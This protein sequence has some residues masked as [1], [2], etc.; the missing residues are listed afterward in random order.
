MRKK[1]DFFFCLL[2]LKLS[3]AIF[4]NISTGLLS[5][6]EGQSDTDN[7]QRPNVLFIVVDDLRPTL[8]CYG[9]PLLRTPNVDNLA[10]KSIL[11]EQTFV[12]VINTVILND[13]CSILSL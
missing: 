4:F 12:Q 10:S 5:L 8:G 3:A 6:S 9:E 1:N 13:N 7:T 2:F 11:F